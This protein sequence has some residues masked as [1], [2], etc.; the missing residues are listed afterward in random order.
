M[1]T[2]STFLQAPLSLAAQACVLQ[3]EQFQAELIQNISA[4]LLRKPSPP[5]LLRAPTG[6]GKTFVMGQI[7]ERVGME[8]D[9]LWF[10]FVP[11]VS[12]VGQTLDA[13]I[14]QAPSLSP[15]LFSQG[16]NQVGCNR[17]GRHGLKRIAPPRTVPDSR[18][19]VLNVGV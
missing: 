10:W 8:R 4:A 13:L 6:S 7:L 5:C 1:Q 11:F 15:V 14:Q 3:P 19:P 17:F 16:R 9:T 2:N 18:S 12:L